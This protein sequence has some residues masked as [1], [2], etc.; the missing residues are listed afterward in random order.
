M[1]YNFS[2]ESIGIII[3]SIATVIGGV[4][5]VVYRAFNFGK[6]TQRIDEIEK[7]TAQANCESHKET[8]EKLK[9]HNLPQRIKTLENKVSGNK[10]ESHDKSIEI[11]KESLNDTKYDFRKSVES[12][13]YEIREFKKETKESLASIKKEL[14]DFKQ[15]TREN[16]SAINK[17]LSDFKQETRENFSA[18]NKDLSDFKQETR[19]NFSAIN[20]DLSDFK[21]ETR[22]NISNLKKETN[23]NTNNINSLKKDVSSIIELLTFKHK[24]ALKFFAL[25]HSPLQL[26]DFGNQLIEEIKGLN[27]INENKDFLI[28]KIEKDNPRTALDVETSAF[29]ACIACCS[30]E[31]FDYIKDFIYNSPEYA[32]K[33]KDGRDMKYN[34]S[35]ADICFVLSIPLRDMY[36]GLHPEI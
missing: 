8:I 4:W 7:R 19:E 20:K 21:Q 23:Q 18:I 9:E 30:R 24:D 6:T 35:L 5:F 14:N 26:N 28:S 34:L 16:F 36:L 10:C 27:F 17:D 1:E 25:K 29:M 11:L 2:I 32:V 22:E 31:E 13:K 12:L 3:G 33:D 15:E